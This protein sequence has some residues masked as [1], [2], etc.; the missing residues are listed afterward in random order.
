M[1]IE[2]WSDFSCPFCYIGKKRFESALQQFKYIDSV[3]VIYKSYQL[4]PNAPKTLIGSAYEQFSK[5]HQ[6]TIEQVKQRFGLISESAKTVGLT[7]DYDHMQMT[8]TRDAHRLQK[9]AQTIG[10]GVIMTEHLMKAYFTD[11]KNLSDTQTL[12]ELSEALGLD[13]QTVESVLCSN[14]FEDAVKEDI[15]EAKDIGVQG[16]PFFVINRAYGVSGAQDSGYFLQMLNQIYHEEQKQQFHSSH[17][18]LCEGDY[19]E[20]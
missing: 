9:Y 15:Q 10:K 14:Q 1:K 11:G 4:N 6:L 12:L 18:P 2:I 19:C 3:E 13:G 8:N 7:F 20:R 5:R 17:A 16:V